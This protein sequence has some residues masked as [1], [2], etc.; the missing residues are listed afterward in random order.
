MF[1]N[2]FSDIRNAMRSLLRAPLFSLSVVVL[3]GGGLGL[4]LTVG[5]AAWSL[6]VRPLPYPGGER[7]V[8]VSGFSVSQQVAFGWAPGLLEDLRAM[9]EVEA[10]GTYELRKP[11]FDSNGNEFSQAALSPDI[12]RLLGARP[13]LGGVFSDDPGDDQQVMLSEPAWR[14]RFAADPAIVGRAITFDGRRLRVVGVLGRAF[15][16]PSADI[17]VWT[18]LHY[19]AEQLQHKDWFA[20]E[21]APVLVRLA[22][23]TDSKQF[24]RRLDALLGDLP[25]LKMLR[26]FAHLR[27]QAISLRDHWVGEKRGLL[28]LLSVSVLVLLGLLLAN[29]VT[30]WIGR[31]VAR[32]REL[33]LRSVL[34]AGVS[35]LARLVFLEVGLLCAAAW[36]VGMALLPIGLRVM[37]GL[38]VVSA[39]L[40]WVV[41]AGTVGFL[42][43]F[44]LVVLVAVILAL[45]GYWVVRRIPAASALAQSATTRNAGNSGAGVQRVLVRLQLALAVSM[46]ASGALLSRSM[47]NLLNEDIGFHADG[48]VVVTV[49]RRDDGE[50]TATQMRP[51]V[52]AITALPGVQGVSFSSAVPFSGHETIS[53]TMLRDDANVERFPV[54]D[55]VVGA[56]YFTVMGL[57]LLQGRGFDAVGSTSSSAGIPG[58]VVD[59]QF[60]RRHLVHADPL[61]AH[62]N[63]SADGESPVWVPVIGVVATV[64]HAGLDEKAELGTVYS[65]AADPA[66]AGG[67]L[68][69]RSDSEVGQFGQHLRE[70]ADGVGLRVTQVV[71]MESRIAASVEER[72]H[73]LMLVLGFAATS[74]IVAAFGLFALIALA[75]RQRR[76][77]F[78]LRIALG[79]SVR[80]ILG[81][82]IRASLHIALP[83]VVLG[84]V[85]ALLFGRLLATQLYQ[86]AAWDGV[87]VLS[88]AGL[89]LL[90]PVAACLVSARRVTRADPVTVL[91]HE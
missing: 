61:T 3:L 22:P 13:L 56:N 50:V 81:L 53:L 31:I 77:E 27:L 85:L 24:S 57:P 69:V 68:L 30:L 18:P 55:R 82:A 34:G 21:G 35:Q 51:M 39:D 38:G 67:S 17:A 12:L 73:L 14:S 78:A 10:L 15:R 74:A 83:G 40:P 11:L 87:S 33:A 48:V 46:L 5:T 4:A 80:S 91:R 16:F 49:G 20:L 66:L 79:A 29:V 47:A 65:V 9:P 63:F 86:I 19:S 58:V 44:L 72:V 84:V 62:L 32:T 60:V 43:G 89:G 45:A 76:A 59:T 25:E 70:L 2:V 52:D 41:D 64:R 75:I 42:L 23:H 6:L 1:A 8:E 7:L 26:E 54:R 71:P 28:L 37:Q 88:A 36:L 90:L